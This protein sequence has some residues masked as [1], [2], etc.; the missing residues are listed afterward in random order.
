KDSTK[1]VILYK[2]TK[3]KDKKT[4]KVATEKVET[5]RYDHAL[6]FV[7]FLV[8]CQLFERR[9]ARAAQLAEPLVVRRVSRR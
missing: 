1:L 4:K 7:A 2:V 5:G 9:V 8:L 3:K 6:G